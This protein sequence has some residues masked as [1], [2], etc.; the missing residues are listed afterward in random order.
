M[1]L[2]GGGCC[3]GITASASTSPHLGPACPGRAARLIISRFLKEIP[4][5]LIEDVSDPYNM[6][7]SNVAPLTRS[8][9]LS[10]WVK[11]A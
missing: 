9:S 10:G 8:E 2:E 4:D 1:R 3:V 5:A 11:R 6:R 7:G